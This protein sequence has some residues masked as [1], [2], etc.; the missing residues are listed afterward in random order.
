MAKLKENCLSQVIAIS[1]T[2]CLL[3]GGASTPDCKTVFNNVTC[4]RAGQKSV[5]KSPMNLARAHFGC[6]LS[7]SER[8]VVIIGGQTSQFE[9]TARCEIYDIGRNTWTELPKI[10]RPLS[11]CSCI[12][13]KRCL[14]N[15]GGVEKTHDSMSV[16]YT[17][18]R[19]NLAAIYKGWDQLSV[20]L[21]T[22][23]C[24]FGCIPRRNA[25]GY[26]QLVIFGGWSLSGCN[27]AFLL[28]DDHQQQSHQLLEI[29]TPD[30]RDA[31]TTQDYFM[32]SGESIEV[33]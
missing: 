5:R 26:S 2:E 32:C 24:N 15:I 12:V 8:A 11:N 3:I 29:K 33:S 16:S 10:I 7:K 28:K 13:V 1:D 23:M 6:S 14:Y 27:K 17:I 18:E 20:Q 31:L 30:G 25:M 21:P 9:Q 4:V 19:L 22:N